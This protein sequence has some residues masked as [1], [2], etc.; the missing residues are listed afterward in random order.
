MLM[1]LRFSSISDKLI[2]DN[3]DQLTIVHINF[4]VKG[5]FPEI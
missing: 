2:M 4:E 3:L 1:K 5:C